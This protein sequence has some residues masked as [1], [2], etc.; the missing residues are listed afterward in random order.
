MKVSLLLVR[1]PKKKTKLKKKNMYKLLPKSHLIKMQPK[2]HALHRLSKRD[3]VAKQWSQL[4][5]TSLN[6]TICFLRVSTLEVN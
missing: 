2:I 3:L 5:L 1:M 4:S 6:L